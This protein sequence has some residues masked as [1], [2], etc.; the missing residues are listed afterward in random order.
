VNPATR[1]VDDRWRYR[2]L[3]SNGA[4]SDLAF[5]LARSVGLESGQMPAGD[6]QR[7]WFPEMVNELRDHWRPG[8]SWS[9]LVGLR[10]E[11]DAMLHRIR[12]ERKI[13]PPIVKCPNCHHVGPAA[14]PDVSVRAMLI[15][16][17]RFGIVPIEDVK[18]LDKRW[19]AHRKANRLD[20]NGKPMPLTK[21]PTASCGH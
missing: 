7:T 17:G 20:L 1:S 10:D 9:Q 2:K 4:A 8:L 3:R 6:A 21:A 5:Q 14:E 18:A 15:A 12:S 16:L 13:R 19:A 11:F